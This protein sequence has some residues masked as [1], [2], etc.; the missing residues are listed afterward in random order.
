MAWKTKA[1]RAVCPLK[2]KKG[3]QQ[4]NRLL[5][6]MFTMDMYTTLYLFKDF[7]DNDENTIILQMVCQL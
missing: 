2:H 4:H 7:I 1:T 3:N 5:A 6:A